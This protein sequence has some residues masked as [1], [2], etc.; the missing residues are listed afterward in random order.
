[1]QSVLPI[2]AETN[3]RTVYL[4]ILIVP[5]KNW[6]DY[7]R[8]LLPRTKRM[9][10]IRLLHQL[11]CNTISFFFSLRCTYLAAI[12]HICFHVSMSIC[13]YVRTD[14]A[15]IYIYIYVCVCVCVC[16][17]VCACVH[18]DAGVSVWEYVTI[19]SV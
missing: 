19:D 8:I 9:T 7:L 2:C 12:M 10:K 1:M 11:V 6:L 16:L 14:V 18:W 13:V 3:I 15:Y 4:Y 5:F 17:C